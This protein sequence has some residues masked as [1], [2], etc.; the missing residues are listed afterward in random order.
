LYSGLT[1]FE[2]KLPKYMDTSQ[3]EVDL[4]P[5]YVRVNA[6]RKITQIKFDHEIISDNATIQRSTTTGHLLIK[7]PIVG[8]IPREKPKHQKPKFEKKTLKNFDDNLMVSNKIEQVKNLDSLLIK[9]ATKKDSYEI[10]FD[11]NEVPDLD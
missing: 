2:L 3:V 4:T 9:E 5:Q 7:A 1:T 11:V 6:K 8:V 10:D